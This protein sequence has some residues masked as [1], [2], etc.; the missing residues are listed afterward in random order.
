MSSYENN[1][2]PSPIGK[3][4]EVLM[5]MAMATHLASNGTKSVDDVYAS[6]LEQTK[7]PSVPVRVDLSVEERY[8]PISTEG[9]I[10]SL[11]GMPGASKPKSSFVKSF[12]DSM[13]TKLRPEQKAMLRVD[14]NQVS[15]SKGLD[16]ASATIEAAM[17]TSKPHLLT[18]DVALSTTEKIAAQGGISAVLTSGLAQVEMARAQV[19]QDLL[20]LDHMANKL[21]EKGFDIPEGADQL[22][23]IK[24]AFDSVLTG[25]SDVEIESQP[26]VERLG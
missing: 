20:I 26:Q 13:F 1:T 25:L 22:R 7:A 2:A 4:D 23:G 11:D 15:A 3:T 12:L 18:P 17:A 8:P 19:M 16:T 5:A 10:P 24:T 21:R 9:W 6:L 14:V